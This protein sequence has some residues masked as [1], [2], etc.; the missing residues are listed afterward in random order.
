MAEFPELTERGGAS[1]G[2]VSGEEV[3]PELEVVLGAER[4][5]VGF[6]DTPSWGNG[7]VAELMGR[8]PWPWAL[9]HPSAHSG[10]TLCQLQA[11]SPGHRDEPHMA[12]AL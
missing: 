11:G 9:N 1:S 6:E 7:K 2:P 12:L 3:R 8:Q 10:T 4:Q 5:T